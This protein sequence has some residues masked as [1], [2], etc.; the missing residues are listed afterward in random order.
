MAS[1]GP[2]GLQSLAM[3]DFLYFYLRLRKTRIR[4]VVQTLRT[5]YP[6]E[7]REQLARRVIGSH[8]ELSAL[9][10]SLIQLPLLLPGIG[11]ALKVLGFVGG[12]SAFARAHIYLILEIALLY[13]KDIDHQDRVPEIMGVVA[14]TAAATL[15]PSLLVDLAGLN[16]IFSLP[17]ALLTAATLTQQIGER[18]IERFSNSPGEETVPAHAPAG[19]PLRTT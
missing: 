18:A 15:V 8:T 4:S 14:G 6:G 10:G 1:E 12:L 16:P 19:S 7:T 11:Q 17:A 13:D 9:G 5:R 2:D 3:D